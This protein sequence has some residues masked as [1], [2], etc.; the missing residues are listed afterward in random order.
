MLVK[1]KDKLQSPQK[2]PELLKSGQIVKL[3]T[4]QA[5]CKVEKLLGGGGQGEVYQADLEGQAVALK[6]YYPQYLQS[7]PNLRERLEKAI[8][9]GSPSQRFLWVMELV[10][11]P[12]VE[13]FGY[14]MQLRGSEYKSFFDLMKRKIEPTFRA[15]TTAGFQLA[16][17]FL[18]LHAKGLCY[19]DIS[20]G[21][22]FIDPNTGNI[23]IC[24]SDNVDIDDPQREIGILGTPNFMAP[25]IVRR[26]AVPSTKTDLYS[27]AVLLFYLLMTHHPLEGK[28]E[29]EIKCLDLPAK[30]KL[31]G[32][33]PIFIYD[34]N[35]T[36]NRPVPGQ[37]DNALIFWELYPEFLKDLF[38]KAFTQGLS[39]PDSRVTESEWRKAM[40]R[41]RDSIIY[42][43]NCRAENFYDSDRLKIKGK[44]NP[45][46]HCQS[47]LLL[48]PRI[49]IG[50]NVI[51][52]NYDTKLFEHH[53]DSRSQYVF[54]Q[55][56]AQ[57]NQHP[58]N[59]SIWG[60]KNLSQQ[61]WTC[62]TPDSSV[63][64]IEPGRSVTLAGNIK[65]NFGREEGEIRA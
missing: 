12:D 57:V 54:S 32:K 52:L 44:L 42:C 26:E 10:T 5:D 41:L 38:V 29:A 28:K 62:T 14:V 35:D 47:D 36:S 2:M 18:Q 63:K 30:E 3:E 55:P 23:Q 65:I 19:S 59:P 13:G 22:V 50:K 15:L 40:I 6:W 64:E 45:C 39:A 49:R 31:Y 16:D 21:N 61:S 58:T 4:S 7:D 25:E 8:A 24:D 46:W 53:I 48:P 33:E 17:S 60:L 11:L 20:L 43:P 1:T 34:P 56:V 27:L 9:K 37:Q 51:M